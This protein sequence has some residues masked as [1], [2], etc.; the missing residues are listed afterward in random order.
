MRQASGSKMRMVLLGVVVGILAGGGSA[1]ADFT[2]S[3]RVNLGPVVN[4]PY[5]DLDPFIAPDGLSLYFDSTRP[6]GLGGEDIWVTTRASVSDAWGPPVHLG[7]PVN[8]GYREGYP[9]ITADGLTLVFSAK[10]RAGGLGGWD[11]WLTTRPTKESPWGPP[12]NLGSPVNSAINELGGCISPDGCSL[13]FSNSPGNVGGDIYVT[14]RPTR[15]SP[16]GPPAR[17]GVLGSR[18]GSGN[19]DPSI[20]ADGL[21]LFFDS[22]YVSV[23]LWPDIWLTTRTSNDS[24]WGT[25]ILLGPEINTQA[26]ESTPSISADGSTL[27]WCS[28]PQ[29]NLEGWDLWQ[30]TISPIV[31]FTGDGKVDTKDILTLIEH[32]G[33]NDPLCDIGP[34]PWGDGKVDAADLE[35]LMGY[36][37]QEVYDSTLAHWKMDETSGTTAADSAGANNGTLV[38]NPT[39]Q[40]T[41]GKIGGA[42]Q[43][44]GVDD[45]VTTESIRDPSEG[46]FSVF[47]WVKGG[48]P[49]QV[50]VSQI[51]GSNWLMAGASDGGLTTEL[52]GAGRTGK[53]LE[54]AASVTDGAWHRVGFVWDGSNRALYVD[55]VEVARDTQTT[56]VGTYTGLHVGAGSTLVPGSFWSGLIDDVRIYNRAVIP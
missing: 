20:S 6:G 23:A 51:K 19:W 29:G 46:A 50:I 48:A 32:W 39:W 16:W 11:I 56:L 52:K 44:D 42:L 4:S 18:G 7:A 31:D 36:W 28:G 8:S 33:Q 37:G 13:Y 1:R 53:T 12:V 10:D 14:T 40:P 55:D 35:V 2:F 26:G 49:G 27:Y 15:D 5:A 41:G 17:L 24:K 47:A 22:D 38:G 45:C 43:F 25:P 34:M 3:E 54:S 21:A 30:S 9:S